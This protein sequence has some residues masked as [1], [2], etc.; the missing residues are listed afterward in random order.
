MG[1]ENSA[2]QGSINRRWR[3]FAADV[4]NYKRSARH[5]VT[6][7]IVKIATNRTRRHELR[8][9]IQILKFRKH[10][11]QQPKLQLARHL[12]VTLKAF[13]LAGNL[14]IK[15]RVLDRNRDLRGQ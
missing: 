3:A 4:A 1:A 6:D 8:R 13:L 12:E 14:L 5:G 10:R 11:W 15:S 2:D 7:K 9:Y